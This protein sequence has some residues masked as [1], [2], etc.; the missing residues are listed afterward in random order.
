MSIITN[1]NFCIQYIIVLDLIINFTNSSFCTI[2]VHDN[3][4]SGETALLQCKLLKFTSEKSVKHRVRAKTTILDGHRPV[5]V[6]YKPVI[7][8]Y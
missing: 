8:S 7:G 5:L 4:I 2:S 1:S 6:G 3:T